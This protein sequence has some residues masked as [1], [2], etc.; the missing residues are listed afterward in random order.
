MW[1][2]GY[3]LLNLIL[4]ANSLGVSYQAALLDETKKISVAQAGIAAPVA[5]LAI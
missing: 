3:Q 4:Q 5:V 2:I 1:E